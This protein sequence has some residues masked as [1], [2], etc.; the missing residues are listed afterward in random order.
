[1]LENTYRQPRNI[2][3]NYRFSPT[4]SITNEFVFGLNRFIYAFPNPV[5]ASAILTPF[6]PNLV[7]APLS[8]SQGN[9]R[10]LTTLQ[11]VDNLAY[12][13]GAHIFKAGVNLRNGREIDH[14]GSIGALNASPQVDFSATAN[15]LNTTQYNTP[16]IAANGINSND[17]PNLYSTTNDLLGR[18]GTVTAGYVAQ[19]DLSAFKPAGSTNNMDARWDEYDFY[20]Q[21]TWHVLPNLVIDY[22]LRD[23]MRLAPKF[24]GFPSLVPNQD[25][26]YGKAAYIAPAVRSRASS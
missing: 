17:L 15:P 25:V 19:A 20:I 6:N 7:T 3:I 18:I 8:S 26:T 5:F 11:Y 24:Q 22:G 2:A 9:N 21:D 4:R 12:A 13:R 16:T 23:D 14:R 10:Y 1:M